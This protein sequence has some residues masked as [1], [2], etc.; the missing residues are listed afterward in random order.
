MPV[1]GDGMVT[2][3]SPGEGETL[4]GDESKVLNPTVILLFAVTSEHPNRCTVI[5]NPGHNVI[6]WSK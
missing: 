6:S 3:L 5:V 4:I 2:S 1:G